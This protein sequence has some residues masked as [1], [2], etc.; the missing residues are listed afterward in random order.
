M[1]S[2][3]HTFQ[4]KFPSVF[5]AD[6]HLMSGFRETNI[7]TYACSFLMFEGCQD[8]KESIDIMVFTC[9]LT[10]YVRY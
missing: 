10:H 7:Y 4:R 1:T 6:V 5:D 2:S 8:S 9:L 3:L